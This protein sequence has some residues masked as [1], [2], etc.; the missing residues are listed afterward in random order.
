MNNYYYTQLTAFFSRTTWVSR[1]QKDKSSLDL[2]E[3]R[4]DGVGDA[5]ASAG[6]LDHMQT[7]CT[8][9]QIDNHTNSPSLSF[10]QAV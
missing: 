9:L 4:D 10:L 1:H 2:N 6:L 8:S 7:V 5:V 3:A